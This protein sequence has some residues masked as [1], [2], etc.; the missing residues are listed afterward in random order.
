MSGLKRALTE[1]Y[2]CPASFLESE[3][4]TDIKN[5]DAGF[6]QFGPHVI[7]YGRSAKGYRKSR[8]GP[9]LYD[10]AADVRSHGSELS[11]PFDVTE[12]V[13]NLRL[14]RYP[15]T[16]DSWIRANGRKAYY[17]L[18]PFLR[19]SIRE[20]IQKL[21]LWGWRK[22]SFPGWPVDWTVESIHEQLLLLVLRATGV[23]RIPFIWFWPHGNSA[24]V[25]ITHDVEAEAGKNFCAELMDLDDSYGIKAA[26][27]L[28]PEGSYSVTGDFVSKIR[29]RG[30]EVGIQDLNH[31]GRLYDERAEFLRRAGLINQYA[32]EYGA[33]GFRAGVLYR[34]P[35]WYD[36]FEFSF[37][38]SIPNTARLDPQRGGCCTV[39]PYFIGKILELPV[40][41]IQDYMLFHLLGERSIDLWKSQICAIVEKSGLVSVIVHPDYVMHEDV[42]VLYQNLLS[43]LSELQLSR[44]IWLALPSD[45]DQWWRQRSKMQLVPNG[46]EWRVEG[47]GAELAVVA[48]ARSVDEN[49]LYE[50]ESLIPPGL[51]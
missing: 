49:L 32:R 6:F 43:Y 51:H 20:Q 41:T 14:E 34:K 21:Q 31:D 5:N 2:R 30:F 9:N 37:D 50:V 4:H 45:V 26:F 39:M 18:R 33:K 10:V 25:I 29:D 17:G 13:A 3:I 35:E 11:L 19:R 24:C 12:I 48:Y 23:D 46:K 22:E 40:T 16:R 44:N 47:E 27:Q 1:R 36:V 42:K 8:V 28:V 7:C 15:C 38:M